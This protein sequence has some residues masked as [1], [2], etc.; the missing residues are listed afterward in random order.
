MVADLLDFTRAKLADGL[1]VNAKRC[2]LASI[3]R[4]IV[5][6]I[7]TNSGREIC[8]DVQGH[9]EGQWDGDR[10]AQVVANLVNNAVAHGSDSDPVKVRVTDEQNDVVLEVVNNAEPIAETDLEQLFSPFRQTASRHRDGLGLGLFI[11]RQI[12]MSHNGSIELV[13][14]DGQVRLRTVWPRQSVASNP[15]A[16]QT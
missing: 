3:T 1:P 6:E 7:R 2:D 16:T 10:A 12:M 5:D 4:K 8:V 15:A 14:S 9:C 13:Q 11:A